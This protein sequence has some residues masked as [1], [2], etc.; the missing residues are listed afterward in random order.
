MPAKPL[1]IPANLVPHGWSADIDQLKDDWIPFL[2]EEYNLGTI[3]VLLSH[4][5]SS[6][7]LLECGGNYCVWNTFT[8]EVFMIDEP[9]GLSNILVSL[10]NPGA[11][12]EPEVKLKFSKLKKSDRWTTPDGW[13]SDGDLLAACSFPHEEY[14]LLRSKA[15]LVKS[16]GY[17]FVV[18]GPDQRLY[19]W[20]QLYKKVA[21]IEEP[22]SYPGILDVLR[23]GPEISGAFEFD[24]KFKIVIL[25]TVQDTPGA[26]CWYDEHPWLRD[27]TEEFPR[28]KISGWGQPTEVARAILLSHEKSAYLVEYDKRYYLWSTTTDEVCRVDKPTDLKGIVSVLQDPNVR[29]RELEITFI[30]ETSYFQ[31]QKNTWHTYGLETYGARLPNA[32][33]GLPPG[34][35]FCIDGNE[36]KVLIACGVQNYLW[37]RTW[38]ELFRIDEPQRSEDIVE[39]LPKNPRL[40][41]DPFGRIKYTKVQA[42]PL[43]E[44][45]QG[46]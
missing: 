8:N 39:I 37:N 41:K 38:N 6:S 11:L 22:D 20:N 43:I 34:T 23:D 45:P 3:K 44:R 12:H 42:V 4:G 2:A 7:Y 29:D 28:K 40:F 15:I 18:C 31:V 1:S 26:H 21:R 14:G 25:R 46:E 5:A 10:N 30:E 35:A 33:Y 24:E 16:K 13:Q 9:K 36:T 19:L 17:M 32:C 27:V